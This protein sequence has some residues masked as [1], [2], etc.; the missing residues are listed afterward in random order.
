MRPAYIVFA[1]AAAVV[2]IPHP[3]A[4]PYANDKPLAIR[5]AVPNKH[6]D[7]SAKPNNLPIAY[8]IAKLVVRQDSPVDL[9]SIKEIILQLADS[10]GI[11]LSD[12]LGLLGKRQETK[13]SI[14]LSAILNLIGTFTGVD[15]S[16][17]AGLLGDGA[18]GD[19][20]DLLSS[21]PDLIQSLLSGNLDLGGLAGPP[22]NSTVKRH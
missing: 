22:G 5:E 11:G 19:L 16:S 2:A 8:D 13:P 10:L 20:T 15:P 1:F 17:L 6:R 9:E 3:V 18:S 14:D 7:A 4:L 12:V 21:L